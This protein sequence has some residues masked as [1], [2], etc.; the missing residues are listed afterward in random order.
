MTEGL[1]VELFPAAVAEAPPGWAEFV[2]AQGLAAMWEWPMVSALA[3]VHRSAVVGGLVLDG[4]RVFGVM[5]ARF[6]GARLGR[7]RT[8]LLGVFDVD[9]VLSP[10]LPGIMLATQ[11]DPASRVA[12]LT[13]AVRAVRV[14]ARRRYGRRL[15]GVMLRQVDS[16]LLPALVGRAAIVREGGPI[17]VFRN[18]FSDFDDYLAS[19]SYSRRKSLRQ[20][21]RKVER[22]PE[23]CIASTTDG[24]VV[25]PRLTAAQVCALHRHTV[26]KHH[27]RW[28]L[29]KRVI[30]RTVAQSQL[31]NPR[32]HWITYHDRAG[33]LL[34]YESTWDHP[35]MPYLGVGGALDVAD[36]SFLWF[37]RNMHLVRWTIETGRSGFFS[38]QGSISAKA[39]LGYEPV[40]QFAVLL[41]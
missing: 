28:W 26:D 36:R 40:R 10:S 6:S 35:T 1:R 7:G 33:T 2:T 41:P 17:A 19:L 18:R 12:A 34:R 16:E 30:E 31:D 24:D 25:A 3:R 37:H 9:C 21:V 23:L 29:R 11:D 13:E 22:N 39:T 14:A 15:A 5:T 38:G 4:S 27:T 8:P 32:I 20:M